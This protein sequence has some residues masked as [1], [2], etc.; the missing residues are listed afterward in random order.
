MIQTIDVPNGEGG[1]KKGN[2]NTGGFINKGIKVSAQSHTLD[3]LTLRASYSYLHTSYNGLTG[4]PKNQYFFGIGWQALPQLSIDAQ[5]RG[6]GGL[7]VANDVEHQNY[8]LL[9]LRIAYQPTKWLEVF[10]NLDNLTDA[11]YQINRGYEMPGF[12]AMGGVKVKF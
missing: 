8:A 11:K 2:V 6:V 10:T 3:V 7:Y 12:T 9:G 4:A 5:L 1:T